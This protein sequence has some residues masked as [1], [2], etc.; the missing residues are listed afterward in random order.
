[1]DNPRFRAFKALYEYWALTGVAIKL[2]P[3]FNVS[4]ASNRLPSA[5]GTND[6]ANI[7]QNVQ[8]MPLHSWISMTTCKQEKYR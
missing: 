1:M 3:R 2:I 7:E 8:F 5:N 6:N 4:E